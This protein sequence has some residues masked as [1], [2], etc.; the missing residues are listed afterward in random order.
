MSWLLWLLLA[1]LLV[2]PV[3]LRIFAD[4]HPKNEEPESTEDDRDPG[5]SAVP[6]AA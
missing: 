6:V 1:A 4:D 2:L 3:F 5:P